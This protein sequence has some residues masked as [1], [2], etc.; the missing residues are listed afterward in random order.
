MKNIVY[1]EKDIKEYFSKDRVKW[2]QFYESE[3]KVIQKTLHGLE[4]ILEKVSVLDVGCACGG[5]GIALREKFNIVNYTGIEINH[6]AAKYAKQINPDFQIIEG[7]FL[8]VSK[9]VKDNYYDLAFS[10]SCIDWQNNFNLMLN[11]LFAKV[12]PGGNLLVSLRLTTEKSI[13]D[14]NQSY[15]YINYDGNKIGEKAPYVIFNVND[16]L[17]NFKILNINDLYAYGYNGRPS[18][19]SVTPY[20]ELCFCVFSLQKSINDMKNNKLKMEIDLPN[21]IV[22]EIK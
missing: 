7:D 11:E 17:G 12:K 14:I 18:E 8:E 3:K 5:L 22:N 13:N 2:E 21:N 4:N 15:Q 1:K 16:L 19:T 6:Q 9:K 20:K 10:F